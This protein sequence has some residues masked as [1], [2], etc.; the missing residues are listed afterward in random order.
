M[1]LTE[2]TNKNTANIAY[3]LSGST[4][5]IAVITEFINVNGKKYGLP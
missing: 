3:A 4:G 2:T 5:I 1:S